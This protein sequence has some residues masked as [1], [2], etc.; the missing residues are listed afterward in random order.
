MK[1]KH[2]LWLLII[3]GLITFAVTVATKT[4]NLSSLMGTYTPSTVN[5]D[6][7]KQ[8]M[9]DQALRLEK[10]GTKFVYFSHQGKPL[11]SFGGLSDF[12]FYAAQDAYDYKLWADW[13]AEHGINHVRAYPPMS[14]NYI[15]SFAQQNGGSLDNVLFPYEEV[16]PGSRQFDLT[17]FNDSYW[18]RFREQCEYLQSKGIIIHLLMINGW[19]FRLNEVN[20]FGHFFNPVNN[21]NSFSDILREN[22]LKFYHSVADKETGLVEAQKAWFSKLVEMTADLDNVYYDLVHEIAENHSNWSKV[23]RWINV[24]AKTVRDRYAELE[25]NKSII[26]GM[27]TGG[28]KYGRF[29]QRS[30][31]FSRPY[32]DLLIYGKAHRVKNAINWR[33]QYKKPYIPQ[34]SWDDNKRKYTYRN[35]EHRVHTR[36]YMWKFMMAKCQQIDLYMKSLDSKLIQGYEH[37]YDPNGW[38]DFENDALILRE[39]WNSLVDYPN[40]WFKG[41]IKSEIGLHKYVLSSNKETVAYISSK[42]GKQGVNFD[43]QKLILENLALANGSYK[44]DIIKPDT[45]VLETSIVTVKDG[46][47]SFDLPSF[48]DDIAVHLYQES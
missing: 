47:V 9:V 33:I 39:F 1:K 18:Q 48:T 13:A 35:P 44:S 28:L 24:M 42:S 37:N 17:R 14:W 10:T 25:P 11:L 6:N 38:N 2:F 34:E 4:I 7:D 36:K 16:T 5:R 40:L 23:Q 19:Q 20:W 29:S 46:V 41:N 22:R 3:L 21:I 12:I 30:W 27:D 8:E 32:F 15:E 26:L 43:S 31:I 45:G